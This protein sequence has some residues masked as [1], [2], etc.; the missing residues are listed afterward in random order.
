MIDDVSQVPFEAVVR[1]YAI[2]AKWMG[3]RVY[4][5]GYA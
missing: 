5:V 2:W 1:T 4:V 3:Q